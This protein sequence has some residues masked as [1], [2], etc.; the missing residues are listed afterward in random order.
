L[1]IDGK[2]WAAVT[3]DGSAPTLEQKVEVISAAGGS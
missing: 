3:E 2:E 1:F